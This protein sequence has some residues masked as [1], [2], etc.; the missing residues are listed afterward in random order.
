MGTPFRVP[1]ESGQIRVFAR[2]IGDPNRTYEHADEVQHGILAPPTYLTIADHFDPEFLRRP[3]AGLR[4][5]DENLQLE[6]G[7]LSH[8]LFHVT[9]T[10]EYFRH[11][12]AGEVLAASRSEPRI[13]QKQGRRG[14][15]L[16]FIERT[17]DFRDGDGELVVRSTWLDVATEVDHAALSQQVHPVE[18]TGPPTEASLIVE[19][20]SRTRL[21]MY[22]GA[23][24]DFH[25]LHHDDAYARAAGYPSVFAP[26]M[27]IMALAARVL[28]DLV[29]EGALTRFEGRFLGQVWPGDSLY[30]VV[31]EQE[32][33][34]VTVFNQAG[35]DVFT[36]RASTAKL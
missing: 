30:S 29:G 13:W 14:G 27:L 33:L 28:T 24:G 18:A 32:E 8:A 15:R 16:D 19:K 5:P 1:V 26:G 10:F 12:Y 21:V 25:P 4:W 2:S 3:R 35:I 22:V 6:L 36:G 23:T 31:S 9:Q 11:V 17:T 7:G 20:L 34:L